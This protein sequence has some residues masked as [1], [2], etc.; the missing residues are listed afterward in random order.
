MEIVDRYYADPNRIHVSDFS[1]G[2]YGTWELALHAPHRF[3]T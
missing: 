1:M 2:G 3:A